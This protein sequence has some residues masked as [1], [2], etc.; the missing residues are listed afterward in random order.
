MFNIDNYAPTTYKVSMPTGARALG[1]WSM[2]KQTPKAKTLPRPDVST[3]HTFIQRV[4]DKARLNAG[5]RVR[6][7]LTALSATLVTLPG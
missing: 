7:V 5:T 2:F 6:T 1:G 4:F 3:I